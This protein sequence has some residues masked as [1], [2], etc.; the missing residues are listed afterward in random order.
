MAV[1]VAILVPLVVVGLVMLDRFWP[2]N[3]RDVAWLAGAGTVPEDEAAVIRRYLARHR[4][5]RMVGGL[6]GVV[7]AGVVD[8]RWDGNVELPAVLFGGIAG[9]LIGALSAESYRLSSRDGTAAAVAS[10]E[11]REPVPLPRVVW[12]ARA[13]LVGSALGAVAIAVAE[14]DA[15][16]LLLVAA[17][18]VVTAVAE[19]T[20]ARIVGRRRPVLSFRA[21]ALDAR[22]RTFAGRS[23]VWLQLSA[24]LLVAAGVLAAAPPW[25]GFFAVVRIFALL[26]AFVRA[27]VYLHRAAPRPPI[28]WRQPT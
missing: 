27:I 9:V 18:A 12:T 19:A 23:V 26:A 11:P 5:H 14:H 15:G 25:S 3:G 2:P 22:I 17:G 1:T 24:A 21:Q 20:R 8:G 10:L 16:P 13:F 7:A 28:T 4:R 6:L